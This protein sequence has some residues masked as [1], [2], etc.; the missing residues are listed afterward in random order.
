MRITGETIIFKNEKGMYNTTISNKREDGTYENMR[1]SVNF[2][3]G[4]EVENK[5]KINIKDGFLSFWKNKD[6]LPQVKLVI[7]DFEEVNTEGFQVSNDES[8]LPF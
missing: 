4:I 1:I 2:K 5:T 6:G 7:M 3:K 8:D